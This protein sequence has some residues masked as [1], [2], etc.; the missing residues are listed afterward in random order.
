MNNT[1]DF[2]ENNHSDEPSPSPPPGDFHDEGLSTLTSYTDH[3]VASASGHPASSHPISAHPISG[4]PISSHPIS[5]HPLPSPSPIASASET[6]LP[7]VSPHPTTPPDSL[8]SFSW[9]SPPTPSWSPTPTLPPPNP[10]PSFSPSP[11]PT[12]PSPTASPSNGIPCPSPSFPPTPTESEPSQTSGS[13]SPSGSGVPNP[14]RLVLLTGYWPPTCIGSEDLHGILWKWRNKME[15]YANSGYDVLALSPNFP[16]GV[17]GTTID[18]ET[19]Q[20]ITGAPYW[21]SGSGTFRVD[22]RDTSQSFWEVVNKYHP[23]AIMSF[24]RGQLGTEWLLES[25]AKNHGKNLWVT[26]TNYLDTHGQRKTDAVPAP[27]A[28]GSPEDY[29][30]YRGKGTILDFPPDIKKPAETPRAG[31]LPAASIIRA[32]K[33]HFPANKINPSLNINGEV[34][35]Y[36]SEYMAYHVAWYREYS[37]GTFSLSSNKQCL[38]S[39]HTHVGVDVAPTDGEYTVDLQLKALFDVLP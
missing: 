14:R 32:I 31:N 29:S 25:S 36:V 21:G 10:S 34:G 35:N 11:T 9:P 30:P 23:I 19:D 33:A 28:G 17:L 6:P 20:P 22:Y 18:R 3:I 37:K 5:S 15:D 4:H 16:E 27:F 39:G 7:S 12:S 2:F 8:P 13:P 1:L 24:S 38:F 26:K